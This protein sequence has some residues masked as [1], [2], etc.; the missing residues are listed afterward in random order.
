LSCGYQAGGQAVKDFMHKLGF[1]VDLEGA[2]LRVQQW[3][4]AN[5]KIVEL[6]Q[7][8]DEGLR[9]FMANKFHRVSLSHGLYAEFVA[10]NTADSLLKQHPGAQSMKVQVSH[11]RTG[12]IF[13]RTFHGLYMRG[14][15]I[16]LYKPTDR[17]TGDLWKGSYRHPKTKETVFYSI[18]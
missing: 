10:I 7:T 17:K 4:D 14:D 13:E 15:R 3:R 11:I 18:Y 1:E 8:L 6:W 16:C 2:N 12:L 9:G 5:P